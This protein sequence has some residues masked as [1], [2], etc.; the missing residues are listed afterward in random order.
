MRKGEGPHPRLSKSFVPVE[1]LPDA[2]QEGA[3]SDSIS[4]YR[5]PLRQAFSHPH[6]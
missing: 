1:D 2:P 3:A 6:P 4:T 5:L